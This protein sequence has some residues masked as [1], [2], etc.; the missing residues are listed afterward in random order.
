MLRL[1]PRLVVALIRHH[2]RNWR[3]RADQLPPD[4]RYEPAWYPDLPVSG[5]RQSSYGP[6]RVHRTRRWHRP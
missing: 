2:Y 6:G 1:H 4:G 3:A 5:S